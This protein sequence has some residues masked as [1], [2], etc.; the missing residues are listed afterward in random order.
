MGRE[1]GK[2]QNKRKEERS[3]GRSDQEEGGLH[4]GKG[5]KG[6]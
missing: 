6:R 5:T 2:R 1:E 4:K 3:R